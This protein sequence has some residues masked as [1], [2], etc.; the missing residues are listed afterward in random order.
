MNNSK[1]VTSSSKGDV[2]KQEFT[3]TAPKT[4]KEEMIEW[5]HSCIAES[6]SEIEYY[7]RVLNE[8]YGKIT[9]YKQMLKFINNEEI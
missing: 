4:D 8:E 5:L 2:L 3:S 1:Y 9:A 7:K 6:Q